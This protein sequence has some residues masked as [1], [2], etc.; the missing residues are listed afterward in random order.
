MYLHTPCCAAQHALQSSRAKADSRSA[1]QTA[2]QRATGAPPQLGH[3]RRSLQRARNRQAQA[4]GFWSCPMAGRRLLD[5]AALVH[6]ARSVARKHVALRA[7]QLDVYTSTSTVP[8]RAG[9]EGL[10]Q[11]HS[12]G[13]PETNTVANAAPQGGLEARQE[14]ERRYPLPDGIIPIGTNVLIQHKDAS[15]HRPPTPA[16]PD[17]QPLHN[18]LPDQTPGLDDVNTAVFQSPRV[19]KLLGREAQGKGKPDTL[20]SEARKGTLAEQAAVESKSYNARS[21]HQDGQQTPG[22]VESRVSTM[23]IDPPASNENHQNTQKLA[24]DIAGDTTNVGARH[25]LQ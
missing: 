3:R 6:A 9:R 19:A 7:R 23:E 17:P 16:L 1:Q 5:V 20:A 18:A 14:R 15:Y 4:E 11:A 13:S 21:V 2:R 10:G 24:A 12:Y 8:G 25:V 22:R